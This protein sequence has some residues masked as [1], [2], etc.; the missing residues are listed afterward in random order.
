MR[1]LVAREMHTRLESGQ[2]WAWLVPTVWDQPYLAKPPFI[3]WCQ[4][5]LARFTG[6]PPG[7]L[8]LRL[9]VAIAGWLGVIVTY[10]AARRLLRDPD[11]HENDP[12]HGYAAWWSALFLAT[13]VL[14]VRSSR[15]G[16]LDILLVP[17]TVGAVWAIYRAWRTFQERA[18]LDWPAL[19]IATACSA[20]AALTKGPPALLAIGLAG[21]GGIAL[22]AALDPAA[23]RAPGLS[24]DGEPPSSLLPSW[25]LRVGGAVTGALIIWAGATRSWAGEEIAGILA[26]AAMGLILLWLATRLAYRDRL[27]AMW[28]AFKHTHPV[29][30][31]GL[32]ALVFWGW[33]RLVASLVGEGTVRAAAAEEAADNLRVLVAR[34]PI[35]NFEAAAYGVGLGSIAA[36]AATVWLLKDRPRLR[37]GWFIVV[38]WCGLGLIAFSTLGKGVPRYLTPLW[39]GIAMLG[40]LWMACAVRDLRHGRVL[41]RAALIA[42]VLL[43]L[44]Q[45][46]WY[47]AGRERVY[48]DRSPRA[49]VA[50]LLPA[51]LDN[52][53]EKLATFEFSTPALDFY[54][55]R[56][57]ESFH[58]A[59]ERKNVGM[60]GPRSITDLRAELAAANASCIL[61]VRST[62]PGGLDP[63]LAVE[64]LSDAGLMWEPIP[65][66]AF[67]IDNGRT[68]VMAL[69]IH[70]ARDP[71]G[72]GEVDFDAL[73]G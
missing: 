13:G 32:A 71:G 54:A 52:D 18:R 34:S 29:G 61:L 41:A 20:V 50:A 60:V 63:K 59:Q 31:L 43:G 22:W 16:E 51:L 24:R 70:A 47:A 3:Y 14:Y 40:G 9:T 15:I 48:A 65:T 46:W 2:R 39:P 4:L 28:T 68:P 23:R 19:A 73:G 7:E 45:G 67:T 21:Y 33:G 12:W 26:L 66:P 37:P 10:L 64:C 25:T 62:Q 38:A 8:H 53:R 17:T 6:G 49:F 5:A 1:A 35:N 69:R 56:E 57:I 44:G 36:I 72:E 55:G 27:A 11:V 30:V 58:D 42:V